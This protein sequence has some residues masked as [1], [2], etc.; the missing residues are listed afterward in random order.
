ML[1]LRFRYLE[2]KRRNQFETRAMFNACRLKWA[3]YC[4]VEEG[5]SKKCQGVYST[6]DKN[7]LSLYWLKGR[8]IRLINMPLASKWICLVDPL[9]ALPYLYGDKKL[10]EPWQNK[11]GWSKEN[12]SSFK[13]VWNKQGE[14]KYKNL[15]IKGQRVNLVKE[16]LSL[17]GSNKTVRW[18]RMETRSKKVATGSKFKKPGASFYE[19]FWLRGKR[20]EW[21]F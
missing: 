9:L 18:A 14:S 4:C 2:C 15:L 7:V 1:A 11:L 3:L 16:A 10:N 17:N 13:R 5:G 20:L 8:W 6:S 19:T 21:Q 12:N